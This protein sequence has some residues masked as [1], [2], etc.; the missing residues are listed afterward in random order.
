MPLPSTRSPATPAGALCVLPVRGLPEITAGT[1]LAGA[2]ARALD[3]GSAAPA[4][5]GD[6]VCISSKIVSKA[7]GLSVPPARRQAALDDATVRV[8]ARRRHGAVTTAVVETVSGPVL[9]AAGMDASNAPDGVL[10]LPADPDAEA[11]ALCAALRS[12]LGVRI[13]VILTDT[14]SRIWRRGV[15]DFALGA[16]GLDV[17]EDLR[18]RTDDAGRPLGVTVRAL[19]DELAAAAD[20]VKGKTGRV[21]AAILRGATGVRVGPMEA[22]GGARDLVRTGSDDWFRRPALEAVWQ[23]LGLRPEQEPVAQMEPEPDAE[24]IARAIEVASRPRAGA[25]EEAGAPPR[26]LNGLAPTAEGAPDELVVTPGDGEPASWARA[27]ML[28]E[29]LRT[30]LA[31]EEI[32]LALPPVPVRVGA[33]AS[34][35]SA[36]EE[37]WT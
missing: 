24:R 4:R 17:L 10:L 5:D 22:S 21:P 26:V 9:A 6:V 19:A 37:T 27:G 8:V 1:D 13:G 14:A 20:L 16:A 7:R 35:A 29:R 30:A 12:A 36:T 33:P 34:D 23:A 3:A 2:L 31:A 15:T 25:P 18:G 11:R 32:A 28:A